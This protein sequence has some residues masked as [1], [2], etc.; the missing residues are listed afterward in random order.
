MLRRTVLH[1]LTALPVVSV[2]EP[3]TQS[4]GTSSTTTYPV[5]REDDLWFWYYVYSANQRER[6]MSTGRSREHAVSEM[7]LTALSTDEAREMLRRANDGEYGIDDM[8]DRWQ[9]MLT[10]IEQVEFV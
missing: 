8:P 10:S 5:E 1:A 9:R 6:V 4:R 3:L 7:D 2:P